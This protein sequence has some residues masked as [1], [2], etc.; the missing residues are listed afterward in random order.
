MGLNASGSVPTLT[1]LRVC[2][3]GPARLGEA[4]E[5]GCLSQSLAVIRNRA[6]R[7]S[8]FSSALLRLSIPFLFFKDTLKRLGWEEKKK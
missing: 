3:A 4:A 5:Q 7:L 2:T 8:G 6:P 1:A